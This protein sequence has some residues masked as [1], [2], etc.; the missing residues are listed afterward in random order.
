MVSLP[1]QL[2]QRQSCCNAS[3]GSGNHASTA[4]S[5]AVDIIALAFSCI[6]MPLQQ[7]PVPFAGVIFSD[8]SQLKSLLIF[9]LQS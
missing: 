3:K 4:D 5:K 7:Q 2:V 9:I 8:G 1:I 6:A